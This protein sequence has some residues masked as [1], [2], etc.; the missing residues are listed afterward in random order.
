MKG[1]WVIIRLEITTREF[2]SKSLLAHQLARK[3]FNVII[4]YEI[5]NDVNIFPKGLYFINSIYSNSINVIK[6]IK[7]RGNKI[8]LLD[9]EGVVIRSPVEYLRRI[10]NEG[11]DLLDKFFCTGKLQHEILAN[12]T[13]IDQSK[14]ITTGNP[15]L[16]MLDDKFKSIEDESVLS[17]KKKH[18][19]FVL[20][21]SNFGTVNIMESDVDRESRYNVKYGTF[22]NQGL[23]PDEQS[24]R[25]FDK[26]F[27]HYEALFQSFLSFTDNIG[28]KHKD[29]NI[30]IRPHPAEDQRIWRTLAGKYDNVSVIYEGNLTEWIKASKL[31]IQNGCTSAMESLILSKPCI[32]YRP[33]V[34]ED[35]DQLLP[36]MLSKNIFE[37]IELVNIVKAVLDGS[38]VSSKSE[39]NNYLKVLDENVSNYKGDRSV[40]EIIKEIELMDIAPS[41]F[42]RVDKF[43]LRF[44]SL[45]R[46]ISKQIKIILARSLIYF[47]RF[48]GLRGSAYDKLKLRLATAERNNKIRKKIID[49]LSVEDFEVAFERYEL[50]YNDSGKGK[51]KVKQLFENTFIV[52][53]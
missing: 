43:A 10:P 52:T 7:S 32:S 30:I 22:Y 21:V 20:I 34:N 18:G 1:K 51:V 49:D 27:E 23:L 41:D 11:L 8:F 25:E 15:R 37:E 2:H 33:I 38:N 36:S 14:L 13:T 26:R 12:G 9:E 3:G 24:K 47:L 19:E 16:N 6:G 29:I 4:K 50:I 42:G 39:I 17:I 35:Y 44:I 5:G 46:N 53:S 48:V 45:Y 40:F 31:V 28:K